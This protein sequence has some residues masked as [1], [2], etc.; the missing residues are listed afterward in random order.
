M[1]VTPEWK[2]LK[3]RVVEHGSRFR[4]AEVQAVCRY[5]D[6]MEAS[7]ASINGSPVTPI[8]WPTSA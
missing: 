2:A 3:R 8:R 4:S 5:L 6:Q 7:L 1:S